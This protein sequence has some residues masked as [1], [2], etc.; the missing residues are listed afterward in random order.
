MLKKYF[1]EVLT[2]KGVFEKW[3]YVLS[4]NT[5]GSITGFIDVM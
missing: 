2:S 3:I 4:E 5:Y 1:T